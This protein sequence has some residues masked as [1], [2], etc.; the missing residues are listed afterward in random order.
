[1]IR[2]RTAG[3]ATLALVALTLLA[4]ACGSNDN[5]GS[6]KVP[7]TTSTSTP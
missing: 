3:A 6:I 2:R 1:M 4:P 7:T 5:G